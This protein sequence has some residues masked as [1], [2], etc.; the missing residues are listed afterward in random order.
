MAFKFERLEVWQE[1]LEYIGITYAIASQLPGSELY[2]LHSQIKRAAVSI[3]LNI[4]EGS[5][6]QT[7]TEQARFLGMA[8]RSLYETIACL[9]IIHRLNYL[10]DR[11]QL[12]EA[13][14][15]A[16]VLVKRLQTLRN[17]LAPDQP[18]LREE[19]PIYITDSA[20]RTPFD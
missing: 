17:T 2:N 12:R 6:G 7:D 1:S 8:I 11:T 10:P 9:H 18:W 4:A 3:N 14:R 20:D 15:K 13:Y 19:E 5:T 16:E